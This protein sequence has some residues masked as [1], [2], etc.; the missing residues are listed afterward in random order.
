MIALIV[1]GKNSDQHVSQRITNIALA[2]CRDGQLSSMRD[3]MVEV[4]HEHR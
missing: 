2:L 1:S 4:H 3:E